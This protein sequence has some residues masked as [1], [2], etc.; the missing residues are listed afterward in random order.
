MR[1]CRD[2]EKN[3]KQTYKDHKHTETNM[4]LGGADGPVKKIPKTT[5]MLDWKNQK[6]AIRYMR[7]TGKLR[8]TQQC[9]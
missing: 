3:S 1:Q 7:E 9:K 5:S 2:S 8:L 6:E 4:Q